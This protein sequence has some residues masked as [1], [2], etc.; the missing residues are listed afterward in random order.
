MS[1]AQPLGID[2]ERVCVLDVE[3][4]LRNGLDPATLSE[5]RRA[6]CALSCS[7]PRGHFSCAPGLF[8]LQGGL[9]LLIVEGLIIRHVLACDLEILELVGPGDVVRPSVEM[10]VQMVPG[11]YQT[12]TVMRQTRLAILDRS[13]TLAVSPWPELAA[14]IGDRIAM[15]VGWMALSTAIREI[16]RID[17]RLL[18]ALWSYADR[19]GRVTPEGVVL[20]LEL[21]HR[22]LAGLVGARRPSVTSA[23]STLQ[24]SGEIHHRRNRGWLLRGDRPV[25]LRPTTRVQ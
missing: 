4:E 9:G 21:T 24:R 3:P 1:K 25:S 20:D 12:W 18:A 13:F 11:P 8:D 23:L 5:Q 14:N 15:R 17:R 16:R 7:L 22:Q 6:A 2:V 10:D 19:W